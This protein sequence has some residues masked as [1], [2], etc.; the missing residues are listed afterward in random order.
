MMSRYNL[1][2]CP[3]HNYNYGLCI[4]E[5]PLNGVCAHYKEW[6][7][8]TARIQQEN[9]EMDM[10]NFTMTGNAVFSERQD[11]KTPVTHTEERWTSWR[12]YRKNL[13][14]GAMDARDPCACRQKGCTGWDGHPSIW[15]I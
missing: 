6:I 14:T 4:P 10:A 8:P 13:R 9:M 5:N 15:K 7:Y 11:Y 1:W 12:I 2:R 3:D